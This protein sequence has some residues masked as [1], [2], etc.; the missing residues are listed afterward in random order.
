MSQPVKG[1]MEKAIEVA[2]KAKEDGDYAIGAIVIKD[3]KIISKGENR[4]K[5]DNDPTAHAEIVAIRRASEILG[6]AYLEDCILYTTHEPCPMCASAA[7]WAKMK[8]I[9]FGSTLED[10]QS[11]KGNNVYSW[12]TI[13]I[14]ASQIIEKGDPKL[15]LV[16]GFMRKECKKLFHS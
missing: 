2:E 3:N 16:K 8:G 4:L 7:I 11:F 14:S 1:F 10:I 6:N 15:E 9:V 13:D 12:R 5:T